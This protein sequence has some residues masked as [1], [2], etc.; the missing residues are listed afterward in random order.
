MDIVRP[1]TTA[2]VVAQQLRRV[3]LSQILE[4]VEWIAERFLQEHIRKRLRG[5]LLEPFGEGSILVNAR[6]ELA[7]EL[8]CTKYCSVECPR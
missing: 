7:Q 1:A 6:P 2:P 5:A 4:K 3:Q 8:L